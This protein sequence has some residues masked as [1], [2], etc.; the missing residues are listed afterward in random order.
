MPNTGAFLIEQDPTTVTIPNVTGNTI[1][2]PVLDFKNTGDEI[3]AGLFQ[4]WHKSTFDMFRV[5]DAIPSGNWVRVNCETHRMYTSTDGAA[6]TEAHALQ[7]S[8]RFVPLMG[9]QSNE[10]WVAGMM[11]GSMNYSYTGRFL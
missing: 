8:V 10:L 5:T 1:T 6:W 11:A 9:A 4:V 7:G 3:E 2:Y